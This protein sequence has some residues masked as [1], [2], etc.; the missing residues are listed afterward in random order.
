[1]SEGFLV[2][3]ISPPDKKKKTAEN[4]NRFMKCKRSLFK[5]EK[6][7]PSTSYKVQRHPNAQPQLT[8]L[9]SSSRARALIN[10]Q[11]HALH[12][13]PDEAMEESQLRAA[14]E[15]IKKHYPDLPLVV[16]FFFHFWL[17]H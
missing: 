8:E 3:S 6:P 14:C 2:A 15:F 13:S 16:S 5:V 12:V 7:P 1:M 9:L 4:V 11:L 17:G 10:R